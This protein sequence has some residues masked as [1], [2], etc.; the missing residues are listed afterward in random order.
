MR[1]IKP[2]DKEVV[3]KA[4]KETRLIVTA[5]DHNIIG[6]LYSAVCETLAG[7]RERSV[8][9][10]VGVRD[11]FAES[12]DGVAVMQKYGLN[13]HELEKTVLKLFN[14]RRDYA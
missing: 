10:P 1:S 9:V 13:A 5:E 12:G 2:L 4:A 14:A 6:G 3:M 7:C 8:V 11:R